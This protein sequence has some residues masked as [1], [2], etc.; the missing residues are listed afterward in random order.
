MKK[1]SL[2]GSLRENVGKKDAK[3]NR[4][5]GLV[6]C[7]MYGGDK[8]IHFTVNEVKLSK[9]VWTPEVNLVELDLDGNTYQAIIQDLQ[10]HPVLDTVLHVD[11]LQVIEDKPFNAVLPV[12]TVGKSPGVAKGGRLF[13]FRRKLKVRGLLKDMPEKIE[14]D[15]SNLD[16]TEGIKVNEMKQEGLSFLDP[17]SEVVVTIKAARKMQA[18]GDEEDE[19]EGEGEGAEEGASEE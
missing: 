4:R 19:E 2:S 9:I 11:F 1:V 15:I 14:V 18:I 7:V 8:Q 10:F 3:S 6:P 17:K 5:N 16:I 13:L 12:Q